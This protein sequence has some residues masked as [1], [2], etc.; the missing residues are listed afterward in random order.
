MA[1]YFEK[2][3]KMTARA[4]NRN[5]VSASQKYPCLKLVFNDN[6]NDYG[7]STWFHLWYQEDGTRV[8]WRS[9]GDLKILYA[10]DDVYEHLPD[11]FESLGAW[12]L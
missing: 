4:D 5:S 7:Y 1:M 8:N 9:I 2:Q 11:A 12:K 6:W 10:E 3:I